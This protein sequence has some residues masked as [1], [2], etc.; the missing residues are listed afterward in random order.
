VL[1]LQSQPV[2]VHLEPPQSENA[3]AVHQLTQII[4]GSLGVTGA[5]VVVALLVGVV[6]GGV[7]FW[8]RSRT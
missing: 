3:A 8:V 4:V 2:I 7:L 1:S 6:I 5:F